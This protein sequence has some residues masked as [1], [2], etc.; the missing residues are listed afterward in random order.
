MTF[1]TRWTILA[2]ALL[3]AA[4]APEAPPSL[5]ASQLLPPALLSGPHFKVADAVKTDGYMTAFSLQTDFG[6]LAAPSREMLE[7]RVAEVPAMAKLDDMGKTEVFAKSFASAGA[8]KAK[9]VANVA[10]NPVETAKAVPQGVG[11]FFKRA[12]GKA[13]DAAGDAKDAVASDDASAG[14]SGEDKSAK[15]GAEQAAKDVSGVSKV[16]R[17]WAQKLGVDPY[18]SN[19]FLAKKLDDVAWAAYA[20]GFTMNLASAAVPVG[21]VVRVN[22]LAWQLPPADLAKRNDEKLKAMGVADATRKAFLDN[23]SFTPSLQTEMVAAL[24]ELGAAAG[25]GDAVALAAR[26]ADSEEDARFFRRNA[27]LLARYH[28]EVEPVATV[29]A[30]QR[31]FIGRTKSGAIAFPAA[32][33]YLTWTAEAD[34]VSAEPAL[35]AAKRAIWLSGRASD[36]AKKELTAR[37]W[38]VREN[39]LQ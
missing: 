12:G 1:A 39:A 7:V 29:Q 3:A 19:A 18:T 22:D 36:A 25:R 4:A 2:A 38:T 37:G 8:K 6:P 28:K 23:K 17:Q 24:E 30:R 33:D 15:D 34:A 21:T 5:R 35:K 13:K 26:E 10:T 11:R 27:L 14:K 9:A 31:L 20:G 32:V 16:R